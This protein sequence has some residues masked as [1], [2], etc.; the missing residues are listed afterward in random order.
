MEAMNGNG[1]QSH[2]NTLGFGDLAHSIM[3]SMLT[4]QTD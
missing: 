3:F 1:H 2:E 4:G